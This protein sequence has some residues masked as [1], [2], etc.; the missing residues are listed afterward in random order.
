MTVLSVASVFGEA[1]RRNHLRMSIGSLFT[2]GD[3][4]DPE[5]A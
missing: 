2:F 1:I 3:E 5:Q 4:D